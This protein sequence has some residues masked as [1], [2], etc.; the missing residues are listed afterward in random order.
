MSVWVKSSNE[1]IACVGWALLS[2]LAATDAALSN[3]FLA[4]QLRTIETKL[5]RAKNRVRHSMNGALIA[6]GVRNGTLRKL[7]LAAAKRI[8]RVEV[9]HGQ[10]S[11]KTPDAASYITKTVAH[12]AQQSAVVQARKRV[13]KSA[14]RTSAGARR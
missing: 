13:S 3:A 5:P 14:A 1:W 2:R 12:R 7:A 11:C 9:D 10:T 8:G 4:D 6:I